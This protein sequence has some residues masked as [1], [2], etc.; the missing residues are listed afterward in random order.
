MKPF[1]V[2]IAGAGPA[3][4]TCAA[5]L[6]AAHYNVKLFDKQL[7][8]RVKPCAGWITPQVVGALDLDLDDYCQNNT[9]Q[10]ITGFRTGM[11]GGRTLDTGYSKPVSFGILRREFDDYL[12]KRSG[13]PC[14]FTAVRDISRKRHLWEVNQATAPLIVGAGGH[15]CPVGNLCRSYSKPENGTPGTRSPEMSAPVVYAQEAEFQMPDSWLSN[16]PV[17]PE[18]PELYFCEDLLGYGWCVRKGSF[19]NIGLGRVEK[20]GLSGEVQ[21]FCEFL[22]F[23]KRITGDLPSRFAGHAYRLYADSKPM[24][25]EDGLMLVGDSAG[26]AYPN[27]GEGIR[28]AIESALIAA[29][30]IIG[31]ADC[32]DVQHL[33]EYER[34]LVDRLG[35][36]KPHRLAGAGWLPTSWLRTISSRL[37]NTR[38]FAKNIVVEKWFLHRDQETFLATDHSAAATAGDQG[39]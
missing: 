7:F 36:P 13:V 23:R 31:S 30:V 5:R 28:P 39:L 25:F 10:P 2:I 32:Y 24:L 16:C 1:D 38:W 18:R 27:S 11:I 9:L 6:K 3:G 12:L 34:R 8:P 19:L 37:L 4:S 14:D 35:T 21:K 15:F 17:D 26:L 29:D 20:A 33:A 22:Q